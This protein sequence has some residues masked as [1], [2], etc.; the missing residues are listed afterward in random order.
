M[1]VA[2]LRWDSGAAIF[3]QP[4][5]DKQDVAAVFIIPDVGE[6]KGNAQAAGDGTAMSHS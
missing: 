5:E 3:R 1:T 4:R 2:P 6:Q